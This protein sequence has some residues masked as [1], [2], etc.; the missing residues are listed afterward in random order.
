MVIVDSCVWIVAG[1][2]HGDLKVKVSLESL[3]DEYEAAFCGPIK[4]EVLG[5]LKKERR[6]PMSFFFEV[7]PYVPM[8]D[9]LWESAKSLSWKLRDAGLTV[10]W[11]DILIA[12]IA[13]ENDCRVYTL[14]Q[15][16]EEISRRTSLILY[17]P[18]YGGSYDPGIE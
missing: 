10:P 8:P 4:L 18:S 9:A 5:A 7:I 1:K 3:L 11:N 2:A 17:R 16:F 6:K 14:D 13:I 12:T 15:H